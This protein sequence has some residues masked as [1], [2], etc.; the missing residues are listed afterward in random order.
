MRRDD[1]PRDFHAARWEEPLIHELGRPGA[2]GQVFPAADAADLVPAAMRRAAPPALP[3]LTEYEVQRHY[4]HLSQQTLGMMGISLF[5]TCTMKFNSKMAEAASLRPEMAETHPLQHPDTLQGSMAII[6]DVDMMLRSLSGMDQFVFQPGGGADAAYTMAALARAYWRARGELGQRD[7]VIT[8]IQA[9]P[10]NPATAAAAGFRVITLPLGEK[11]YPT[12]DSLRAAVS[13]RTALLMINNPDDMGIYNPEIREWVRV[14]KQAGGLCFYDHA[15]FNGVMG[16][17]SA[18]ELGFDAC[19]FMLHKTFGGPK[20]GG[21]PAVGAF[22]CTAALA[23]FLPVP[24]IVKEGERYRA[25]LDRPLS[26]G[27]VR[28]FWG[29]L[30]IV[31][32]AWVWLRAMGAEGIDLASDLSVLANNYMDARLARIPGLARSHPDLPGWRMEMTRWSLG[33][34]KEETGIGTVEVANRMAD[35]GIDPYWMSHEPWIVPEPFTPEAGEMYSREDLDQWIAVLARVVEEARRDPELVRTAPHRQPIARIRGDW[36]ED[37]ERWAMSWAAYRRKHGA[38]TR[39]ASPA[40][41]A[42]RPAARTG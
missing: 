2:R 12:L 37:P 9:H 3:E 1:E 30:P 39:P 7:E 14:V 31:L 17:I 19:M 4:L 5:G 23:P 20:S 40:E 36:L 34:L 10:C 38:A 6:H 26:C 29:N 16:K 33:P 25:D 32:R 41:P 27:K 28:E 21:G 11:G 18:A 22:G 35:Y 42:P 8:S 13:E 24:V 15:N